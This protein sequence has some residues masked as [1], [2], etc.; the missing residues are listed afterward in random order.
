MITGKFAP[1]LLS[2]LLFC[3][4]G[5]YAQDA[6]DT[7]TKESL[8]PPHEMREVR[9]LVGNWD[10]SLQYKKDPRAAGW[11]TTNAE[12][13]CYNV[14]GGA[15][16]Q[17]DLTARMERMP[18]QATGIFCYDRST[19]KWQ[20]AHVDNGTSRLSLYAGGIE[21]RILKLQGED[22]Y[23]SVVVLGR[24]SM[25]LQDHTAFDWT[26]ERSFDNGKTWVEVMKAKFTKR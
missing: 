20:L 15:G 13:T 3:F 6:P 19:G 8:G 18:F 25:G 7:T 5:L 4:V 23:G 10:V 14:A 17:M 12:A 11:S 26:M 2:L 16:V 9:F 24:L 22:R 21:D 1:T